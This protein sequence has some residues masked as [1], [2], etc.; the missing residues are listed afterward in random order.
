MY[1][2]HCMYVFMYAYFTVM[3]IFDYS[4]RNVQLNSLNYYWS[5]WNNKFVYR[6]YNCGYSIYMYIKEMFTFFKKKAIYTYINYFLSYI[7]IP[8]IIIQ[9]HTPP[10]NVYG[11]DLTPV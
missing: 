5:W 11:P 2:K 4:L 3:D 7:I 10:H 9:L 8:S 1:P 6:I